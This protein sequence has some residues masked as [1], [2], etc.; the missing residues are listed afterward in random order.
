MSSDVICPYLERAGLLEF[1]RVLTGLEQL[2]TC[3]EAHGLTADLTDTGLTV[4][5]PVSSA[6]T[7]TVRRTGDAYRT[8]WGYEL[9]RTGDEN[10]TADR[11]AYLL[12]VPSGQGR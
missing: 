8:G 4:S 11:L 6:L 7:E 1:M 2:A 5:N 12:G 10:G 9:G 3:V